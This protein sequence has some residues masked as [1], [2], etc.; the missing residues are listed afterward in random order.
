VQFTELPRW[1]DPLLKKAGPN[2]TKPPALLI[3]EKNGFKDSLIVLRVTD[4][5]ALLQEEE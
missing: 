1:L 4:L 2:T 5:L 3:T